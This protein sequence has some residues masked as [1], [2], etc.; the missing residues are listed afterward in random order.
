MDEFWE[1]LGLAIVLSAWF[2]GI[3]LLQYVAG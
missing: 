1:M 3:A 2:G